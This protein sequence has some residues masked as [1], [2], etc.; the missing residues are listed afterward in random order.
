[1]IFDDESSV[2]FI[3][4]PYIIDFDLVPGTYRPLTPL[5]VF[6]GEDFSGTWE[7]SIQDFILADEGD[8]VVSWSIRADVG[9]P[10]E[11]VPEPATMLLFGTGLAGLAGAARRKMKK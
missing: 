5:S 9:D 3:D 4:A 11:P 1:M 10:G 7:L 8:Q 2:A 6:D